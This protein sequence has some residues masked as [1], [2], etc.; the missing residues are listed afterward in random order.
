MDESFKLYRRHAQPTSV[1]AAEMIYPILSVCQNSVIDY[2]KSVGSK[3]FTDV[4]MNQHFNTHKSTYRA[5]RSEVTRFG[6]IKNSGR[7]QEHDGTMHIVWIHKDYAHD[8]E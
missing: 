4:E 2:A 6:F 5:R 8:N 7:K 3:G 1:L